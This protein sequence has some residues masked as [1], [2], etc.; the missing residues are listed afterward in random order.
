[1]RRRCSPCCR[2]TIFR[3]RRC[4]LHA[5][6][7]RAGL[8]RPPASD[9]D[10][11]AGLF[12]AQ[13]GIDKALVRDGR[14]CT[15][16]DYRDDIAAFLGRHHRV[17]VKPHPYARQTVRILAF[18]RAL[19][20]NADRIRVTEENLYALLS[21]SNVT[22]VCGISS[23]AVYEADYFGKAV[24]YLSNSRLTLCAPDD[25][26]DPIRF[27]PVYDAFLNPGFWRRVL[28]GVC[29]VAAG[30]DI[31]LPRKTS[32]LRNNLS[33]YWGYGHLDWEIPL[34]TIG[35]HPAPAPT[36]PAMSAWENHDEGLRLQEAGRHEAAVECFAA[37]LAEDE[38]AERW[39]DWAAAQLAAGRPREAGDGRLM[40]AR[41]DARHTAAGR[42]FEAVARSGTVLVRSAHGTGTETIGMVARSL[43]RHGLHASCAA[44]GAALSIP[45]PPDGLEGV[46][47]AWAA[48]FVAVDAI[49]R[50][51]LPRT[52]PA[53]AH[54]WIG[55]R[56]VARLL[57]CHLPRVTRL[58]AGSADRSPSNDPL[59][60]WLVTGGITGHD[61][62]E[63]T[64]QEIEADGIEPCADSGVATDFGEPGPSA[65][66][67]LAR[68][69]LSRLR[70]DREH[71][72]SMA[73]WPLR[74]PAT[75]RAAV[76]LVRCCLNEGHPRLALALCAEYTVTARA[77]IPWWRRRSTTTRHMRCGRWAATPTP[78]RSTSAC[79]ARPRR[80]TCLRRCRPAPAITSRWRRASPDATARRRHSSASACGSSRTTAPRGRC[81]T[82]FGA[83]P[84][85][86]TIPLK[87]GD[88]H[89]GRLTPAQREDDN[90][91]NDGTQLT[92]RA[93]DVRSL[94]AGAT[95]IASLSGMGCAAAAAAPAHAPQGLGNSFISQ[96]L[97]E[98]QMLRPGRRGLGFAVGTRAAR[99]D[100]RVARVRDPRHRPRRRRSGEKGWVDTNQHAAS[101]EALNH[102][103][104]CP[105]DR[106]KE[107][108]S[109]RNVDMR[110]LPPDLGQ[111]DFIWSACSFEHLG[112]LEEGLQFV[113]ESV[114]RLKPGGVA[115]HTTE[116]N[117]SSNTTTIDD[118]GV[119]IYRRSDI[120][121]VAE[122]LRG[123]GFAIELDFSDGTLPG[124]LY[125]D[126]HPF[127]GEP[128]LK[129]DLWGYVATSYGL[130]IH[131]PAA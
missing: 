87:P 57:A 64:P 41:A 121:D 21:N 128:H 51:Q 113:M 127:K 96:A 12:T 118:G 79:G 22:E 7:H 85:T 47:E 78:G 8:R 116:Y 36:Q 95:P 109:F 65:P 9:I 37:A 86:S 30:R 97:D 130:I 75:W 43:Y 106:F 77:Q 20:R 89:A 88:S 98:R 33:L 92:D 44:T 38:S 46:G 10:P 13:H 81:S 56:L 52:M 2:P 16:E 35:L 82:A 4:R 45:Q 66:V 70:A 131:A 5:A 24:T 102:M 125:V 91:V 62:V 103:G 31:E 17:Y 71:H 28:A 27:V 104:L 54:M 101:L 84:P 110:A 49:P 105:A 67:L 18:L 123:E 94:H 72:P 15:I 73:P 55:D 115:V 68:L 48:A 34:R 14:F 112:N 63:A 69:W 90:R 108:V 39:H 126:K 122:R 23:C 80:P 111:A 120:E 100:V 40:A 124:D 119:V 83:R 129:L 107:L 59:I 60:D 26:F 1:M 114:K 117:V 93:P 50:P 6:L 19:A 74:T 42:G 29:P 25:A 58:D 76:A 32:R 99:V 61:V 11:D 53:V 3:T